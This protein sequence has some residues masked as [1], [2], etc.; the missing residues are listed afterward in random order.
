M[1]PDLPPLAAP[2][3]AS[4]RFLVM[5]VLRGVALFGVLIVNLTGLGGADFLATSDQLAR[6]P[7]A[8]ADHIVDILLSLFVNDKAN[9]LFA[10]L[11]GLGFWVQMERLQARG[12]PFRTI[13]LKRVS[14]LFLLG[15]VHLFVLFSWD[16][17]HIYGAV[18]VLLYFSRNLSERTML[19]VGMACL[20]F[21]RPLIMW[22]CSALGIADPA[23]DIAYSDAAILARQQAAVGGDYS[24]WVSLMNFMTR[25]DWF[26]SGLFLGWVVYVL[27][28]FYIGAWVARQGWI[29][30]ARDHLPLFRKA[31]WPM[32][33]VG[34]AFEAIR[35]WLGLLPD[36]RWTGII[37]YLSD[38][39]HAVATPLI[40]A[41]Y[42]CGLVLIFHRRSAGWLLKPFAP[43][44][45]MAL[46]NYLLQSVAIMLVLT[47]IGPG[48]GLA[49]EAGASMLALISILIF[50]CQMAFSH[51]WMQSF[52]FGPAEWAWRAL[53]YG[54]APAIRRTDRTPG[55]PAA[56]PE[57]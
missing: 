23:F 43:V 42:V 36:E 44:G 3:E 2:V 21:G 30:N 20:V 7:S 51:V 46:T 6:L 27:G 4:D 33:L 14:L 52:L 8:A 40:A 53:T 1:A 22:T 54:T 34:L 49:G 24:V 11:F 31:L 57:A 50:I 12:L 10:F 55:P 37:P 32:L 48:L 41:G 17:L 18:A 15:L 28:R 19:W 38:A 29:Q 13:Y 56:H 35:T 45:Q 5:D 39:L 9:T 26:A 47:R 16:I 25:Y